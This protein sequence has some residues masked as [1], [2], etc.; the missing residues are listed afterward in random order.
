MT[1]TITMKRSPASTPPAAAG[2]SCD[3]RAILE[4]LAAGRFYASTGVTLTKLETENNELV[5]EA[6]LPG[7]F[8][9]DFIENGRLVGTVPGP[10]ARYPLPPTGYLRAGHRHS[11]QL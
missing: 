11:F 10:S 6:A 9:I 8:S 5:I 2:W 7:T 3:P 1:L 4:S